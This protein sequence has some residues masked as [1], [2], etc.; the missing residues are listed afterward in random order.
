MCKSMPKRTQLRMAEH[1]RIWIFIEWHLNFGPLLPTFCPLVHATRKTLFE[2]SGAVGGK[3]SKTTFL[4]GFC[5]IKCGG[6]SGISWWSHLA[7]ARTR[8]ASGAA[9]IDR[10]NQMNFKKALT[11][12]CNHP[13]FVSLV[14]LSLGVRLPFRARVH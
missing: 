12:L 9:G 7:H 3:T 8:R 4:H 14:E 6:S 1:N 5:K 2:F 10:T 13:Q 11:T